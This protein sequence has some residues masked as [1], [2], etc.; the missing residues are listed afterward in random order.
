LT[1]TPHFAP[2]QIL[3]ALAYEQLSMYEEALIEFQ[4]AQRCSGFEAAAISGMGQIFAATG[5]DNEAEQS[6]LKLSRQAATRYVSPYYYAVIWAGGK[7]A[8]RALSYLEESLRQ[9]DPAL[10]S[11]DA[12]ARFDALRDEER[13]QM[14]LTGLG[15][16][17]GE[18]LVASGG[19]Q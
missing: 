4:N 17:S 18:T 3:L 6:F 7:Q 15:C 12:D 14:C 9:R 1:L 13:F 11:L 8:S 10:L 2:A 19:R 16:L 5:L